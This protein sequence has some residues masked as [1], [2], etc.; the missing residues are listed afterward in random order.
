MEV[1]PVANWI[2]WEFDPTTEKVVCVDGGGYQTRHESL[3][4]LT[5]DA[6]AQICQKKSVHKKIKWAVCSGDSPVSEFPYAVDKV[7][8]QSGV[9]ERADEIY[10][11]FVMDK[12]PEIR[13][14]SYDAIC[15]E[16]VDRSDK[17]NITD[18]RLFWI[19]VVRTHFN[20]TKFFEACSGHAD[21]T[22]PISMNWT[23]GGHAG[24][25]HTSSAYVSLPDHTKYGKLI[26]IEGVGYS[27]RAK[28]LAF[29]NRLL[30]VNKR[31]YWDWP[32][33]TMLKQQHANPA[34]KYV[35]EIERNS[36]N[37]IETLIYYNRHPEEADA[38]ALRC[39]E[40]AIEHFTRQK[41]VDQIEKLL[42]ALDAC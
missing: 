16:I 11:D 35:V 20:R 31:P 8:H 10:P 22:C 32:M 12:W 40:Y 5:N 21:L 39:Q 15:K 13:V 26:D 36:S 9:I 14:T 38:I 3:K 29:S 30:F 7:F 1:K 17:S 2:Y 19:G 37:L 6:I 27:G 4:A 18:N 25:P 42:T 41:A 33:A 28:M 34:V 24:T 23:G